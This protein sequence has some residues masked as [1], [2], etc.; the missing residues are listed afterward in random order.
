M[1][2]PD[3]PLPKLVL[4]WLVGLPLAVAA[5]YYSA[6]WLHGLVLGRYAAGDPDGATVA[7]LVQW[8]SGFTVFGLLFTLGPIW[9]TAV[10]LERSAQKRREAE[11]PGSGAT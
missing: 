3:R 9:G 5:A 4:L 6:T 11:P 10:L 1:A 7:S 2:A 8:L